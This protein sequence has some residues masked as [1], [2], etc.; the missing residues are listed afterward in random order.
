MQQPIFENLFVFEIANNHQGELEHGLAIVRA[1][2]EIAERHSIRAAIKLQYRDLDTFIHPDYAG[3]ADVKHIGRFLGTRMPARDMLTLLEAARANGMLTMV[4]PFDEP[5][6]DLALEHEV[7]ILKVASC[8]A[9]DWPLL[10]RIAAAGLPTI[11]S[12]GG[13]TLRDIDR[14]MNF[15]EHRHVTTLG[16][17]HCIG[18]YPAP[19][20]T[21]HLGFMRTMINRYPNVTVGYS[22]HEGPDE[23]DVVR[24]AVAMGA[25][26]LERHVGLATDRH[27]LNAYS[28]GPDQVE[29]WVA[30]AQRTR[31]ICHAATKDKVIPKEETQS[32]RELSRGV[33]AARPIKRGEPLERAAVYFAMPITLEGQTTSGEFSDTMC[34]SRDYAKDEPI[35]EVRED[36]AIRHVRDVVHEAKAMLSEARI[37][38]GKDFSIELSHHYGIE[39]FRE[40]G[41]ILIDLINREYCKK[42]GVMLPGQRH[43]THRHLKKE[44]T[45]HL[46]HGDLTLVVDGT[47]H[48]L[49][50]GDQCLVGR[51]QRHSFSS[52]GGCIFEEI[53]TTSTRGDSIYD[54]QIVARLDPMQ[55]KTVL[56]TW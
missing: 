56:E 18:I 14:I 46:L 6:V 45:F 35:L 34:A 31:L 27:R 52:A 54:D 15:F 7:D 55:R 32:L 20:E 42:L 4:T 3:R 51:G 49:K 30:A 28:L 43:P 13:R 24:A 36:S 23:L 50:A 33:F 1:M 5:S 2:G 22:A 53:S 11:F 10:E 40:V 19:I 17:L 39:C 8:S 29:T 47:T 44:E 25:S 9:T 41:V 26:I 21:I 48:S 37:A 16:V 38:L 12:T